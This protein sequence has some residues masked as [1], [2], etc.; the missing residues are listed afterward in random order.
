MR[1]LA[2]SHAGPVLATAAVAAAPPPPSSRLVIVAPDVRA[3]LGSET[4]RFA[5]RAPWTAAAVYT[6]AGLAQAAT[7]VALTFLSADLAFLPIR[8]AMVLLIQ[9]WPVLLAAR[10]ILAPSRRL[11]LLSVGAYAAALVALD[12]VP[13]LLGKATVPLH[14]IA[15]L[16]AIEMLLPTLA[17]QAFLGRRLRAVGPMVLAFMVLAVAG[18]QALLAALSSTPGLELGGRLAAAQGSAGL[19]LA[20]AVAVGFTAFAALGWAALRA[21]GRLYE[22]KRISD[23][24]LALDSSWLVFTLLFATGLLAVGPL[25]GVLGLLAFVAYALAV[26]AG[27]RTLAARARA[28]APVTLTLLRTFGSESRSASLLAAVGARWRYLGPIQ[29]ISGTDLATTNLEPHEFL[30]FLRGR[31]TRL[32]VRDAEDLERRLAERDLAP[33]PDGRH[34]IAEFFCHEDTWRMTLNRIVRDSHAVLMDLRG[35]SRQHAGCVF[36]LRTLVGAVPLSRLV[37]L[38]DDTTDM[39]LVEATLTDA[40]GELGL[41]SPSAAG[42]RVAVLSLRRDARAEARAIVAALVAAAEGEAS[43]PSRPAA[44]GA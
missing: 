14:Q 15:L 10:Q 8:T 40:W 17:V 33:D 37:L 22:A 25:A 44:V 7:A 35:F 30:E 11:A 31:L 4:L 43:S 9:A 23:Q 12:V 3:A 32:F 1:E 28:R 41:S 19:V 42:P 16:W 20:E 38:A 6:V 24:S 18:V 39:G 34:R 13:E 36:E 29:T 2:S 26:W 5:L 21:V 27:R